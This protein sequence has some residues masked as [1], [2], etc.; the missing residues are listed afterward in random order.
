MVVEYTFKNS[1]SEKAYTIILN[2][3]DLTVQS[4]GKEETIP[5]DS[6]TAVKLSKNSGSGFKIRIF[7]DV[8]RPI[9]VTNKYYLPSGEF[10]DRSR[11]YT[12]FVRVLHFHLKGRTSSV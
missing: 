2:Q 8:H 6:I 5:Y 1:L 10:E 9:S 11:Q 4:R 7:S 12:A 3:H